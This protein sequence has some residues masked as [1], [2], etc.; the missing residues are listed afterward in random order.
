MLRGARSE[1]GLER[2]DIERVGLGILLVLQHRRAIG[3]PCVSHDILAKERQHKGIGCRPR[4]D[5]AEIA[6]KP[7]AG[8]DGDM[9][10]RN[11]GGYDRFAIAGNGP[12]HPND[13]LDRR[14]SGPRWQ[15]RRIDVDPP[16]E[17]GGGRDRDARD[18]AFKR[19]SRPRDLYGY[20]RTQAGDIG[21]ERCRRQARRR[22][23]KDRNHLAR[24]EC[25]GATHLQWGDDGVF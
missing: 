15:R 23:G 19:D 13:I 24:A 21:G 9:Q 8:A 12:D 17:E 4:R 2:A 20:P 1:I 10:H 3:Q 6:F 16:H 25:A 18:G 7:V 11:A 5:V 22:C 14:Q